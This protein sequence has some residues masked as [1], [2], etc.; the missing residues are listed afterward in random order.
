MAST[1][2]T[3][4][5][6]MRARTGMSQRELA[7]R[8]AVPPATIAR[9][10]K[11]RM[12]PTLALLERIAAAADLALTLSLSPVDP[13]ER[14]ARSAM[15]ALSVADRLRQNDRLNAVRASSPR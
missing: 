5:R 4:C 14:K 10:E 15:R 3:L 13:D 1:A 2:W 9:I 8:A 11:G 6:E 7:Q 12:E